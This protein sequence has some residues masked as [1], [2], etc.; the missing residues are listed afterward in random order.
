[1]AEADGALS[2]PTVSRAVTRYVYELPFAAVVSVQ[3]L[4]AGLAAGVVGHVPSELRR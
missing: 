3:A 2:L 4:P 1:L